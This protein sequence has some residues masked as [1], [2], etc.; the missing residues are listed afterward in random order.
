MFF[1]LRLVGA[2]GL[3]S[4]GLALAIAHWMPARSETL[5]QLGGGLLVASLALLG[6]GFAI[7]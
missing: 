7:I 1:A 6:F 5:E 2:I 3:C 4:G